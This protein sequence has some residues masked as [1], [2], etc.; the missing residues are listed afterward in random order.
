MYQEPKDEKK[1]TVMDRDIQFL[2]AVTDEQ[3][4]RMVQIAKVC[5]V[6]KL[7]EGEINIR[8]FAFSDNQG[9]D[10]HKYSNG[11]ITVV[12]KPELCRHA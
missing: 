1:V 5:P 4:E 11:D 2:G 10:T 6:S 12:W 9:K 3:R 7:L 8:T